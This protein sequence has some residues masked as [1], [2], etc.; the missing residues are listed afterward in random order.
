M[1]SLLCC[2]S[3]SRY[4]LLEESN[5]IVSIKW[6]GQVGSGSRV[7]KVNKETLG[8]DKIYWSS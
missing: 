7:M 6:R 5:L 1:I 3:V 2:Y 4:S 8:G